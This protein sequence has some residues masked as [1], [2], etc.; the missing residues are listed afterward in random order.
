[1]FL[2]NKAKSILLPYICM[3]QNL[4]TCLFTVLFLES[5]I[6]RNMNSVYSA[7]V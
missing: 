4:G 7:V 6:G 3:C 2:T 1:M 5:G